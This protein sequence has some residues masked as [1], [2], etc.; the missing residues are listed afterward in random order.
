MQMDSYFNRISQFTRKM[1]LDCLS[2][3][4]FVCLQMDT[5][6]NP[7]PHF[8][9]KMALDHSPTLK[10]LAT[11]PRGELGALGMGASML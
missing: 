3:R 4:L 5:Y 6:Y 8:T 2:V 9:F 1:A 7:I 11:L 10:N